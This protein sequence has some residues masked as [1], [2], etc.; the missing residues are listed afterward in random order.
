MLLTGMLRKVGPDTR[1]KNRRAFC[2]KKG[3]IFMIY[4]RY[5]T[6]FCHIVT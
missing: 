4:E 3:W 1:V 5:V 2:L 6:D